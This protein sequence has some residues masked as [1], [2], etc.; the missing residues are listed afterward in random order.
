MPTTPEPHAIAVIVLTFVAFFLFSRDRIPIETTSL[1]ILSA[2]TLGFQIFP[3]ERAGEVLEVSDFFLGFGHEALITIS[4][5]M[6]L[7]RGLVATGGKII[8][9]DMEFFSQR[10]DV[11]ALDIQCCSQWP[12]Q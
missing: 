3:F 7:G 9:T 5:L 6:I 11:T 8:F 2:L 4:A 12:G 1:V 10:R